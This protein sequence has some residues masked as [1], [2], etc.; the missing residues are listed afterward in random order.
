MKWKVKKK[1]REQDMLQHTKDEIE[2]KRR[3]T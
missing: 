1:N 2:K 3:D